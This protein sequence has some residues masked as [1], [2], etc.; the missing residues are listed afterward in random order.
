MHAIDRLTRVLAKRGPKALLPEAEA[1]FQEDVALCEA[2]ASRGAALIQ[3]GD[4]IITHC[5]TGGL[6][7]AGRGTALGAIRTAWEQGKRIHVY[8]DE[9]RPLLQGARLTAWELSKL[10]IPFTLIC[11]NMAASL[12]R[13]GRV[14]AA[15]V[16][17]DRVAVNGDVA[18]KIGT[19][20]LAVLCKHHNVPFYVV[21]PRTTY[22]PK[23]RTGAEIPIEERAAGEVRGVQAFKEAKV[24]N[25]AFDVTPRELIRKIIFEDRDW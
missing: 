1:I 21:A 10:G 7:T 24:W 23:C 11:D 25:P 13:S 12:L 5:N 9:T 22:D 20:G 2:M 19:Y 15:F 4:G 16:G 8:V 18:N 6:A 14:R 17:A 3:D